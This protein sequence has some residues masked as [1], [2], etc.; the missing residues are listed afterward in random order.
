M[1]WGV[2]N[3]PPTEIQVW[4]DGDQFV[5]LGGIVEQGWAGDYRT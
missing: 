2:E 5:I 4:I 1:Q 3:Y